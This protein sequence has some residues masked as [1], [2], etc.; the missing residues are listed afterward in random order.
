MSPSENTIQAA[1]AAMPLEEVLAK[2]A[3]RE[4]PDDVISQLR[5]I[6]DIRQVTTINPHSVDGKI[7]L[8]ELDSADQDTL[9]DLAPIEFNMV[10]LT[11]RQAEYTDRKSGEVMAKHR[12]I[13]CTADGNVCATMSG[14]VARV[15]LSMLESGVLK[16]AGVMPLKVRIGRETIIGAE[17]CLT[18]SVPSDELARVR[19]IV[20]GGAP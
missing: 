12:T 7:A 11:V 9:N 1:P 8:F 6:G 2:T 15:A 3:A 19:A 18:L 16:I 20:K 17:Q 14:V 10:N 5:N 13:F 4:K